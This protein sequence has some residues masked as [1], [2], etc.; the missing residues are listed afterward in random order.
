MVLVKTT[1]E[2]YSTPSHLISWGG[3]VLAVNCLQEAFIRMYNRF[4]SQELIDEAI[5]ST[6]EI[7]PGLEELTLN[8]FRAVYQK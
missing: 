5:S 7:E 3:E 4:V 2:D 6:S 1:F 8:E